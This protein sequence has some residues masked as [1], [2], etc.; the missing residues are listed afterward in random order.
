MDIHSMLDMLDLWSPECSAECRVQIASVS[1]S[2]PISGSHFLSY[3]NTNILSELMNNQ[4]V[5]LSLKAISQHI[6]NWSGSIATAL[7]A[8]SAS[9]AS[10]AQTKCSRLRWQNISTSLLLFN[11]CNK[12]VTSRDVNFTKPRTSSQK[13]NVFST[14]RELQ[15]YPGDSQIIIYLSTETNLIDFYKVESLFGIGENVME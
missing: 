7:S 2:A 3:G 15:T 1:A 11:Y 10:S 5:C 12:F 8:D 6:I 13:T 9:P 14:F 4:S